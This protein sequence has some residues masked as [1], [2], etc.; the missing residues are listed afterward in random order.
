MNV[1][2]YNL[3]IDT[4]SGLLNAKGFKPVDTEDG[5]YFSNG[6]SAVRVVYNQEKELFSLEHSK[7]IND[8]P[9]HWE[10]LSSWLFAADAPVKDAKSIGFDFED[11]L[12]EFLGVKPATKKVSAAALP[13]KA[14]PGEDPSP[15]YLAGRFL[16]VFPQFKET[17]NQYVTEQGTFLYVHFFEEVAAPHLGELLDAND[18][19]R[20][21]KFF[22]MLNHVY[23]NGDKEARSVVGAVILAGALR[24]EPTRMETANKY[25]EDLPYLKTAAQFA[26]KVKVKAK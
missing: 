22:D 19:R 9:D 2:A 4:I 24:G 6:A 5:A 25:M 3:I 8:I 20:L 12:R 21:V 17:Y 14:D 13:T 15:A 10:A 16:T 26:V 23:C 1:E 7:V 11:T 18:K